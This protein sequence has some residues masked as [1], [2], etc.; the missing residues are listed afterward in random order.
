MSRLLRLVTILA[1]GGVGLAAATMVAAGA[2]SNLPAPVEIRLAEPPEPRALPERTR[3]FAADGTSIGVLFDENRRPVPLD[4]VPQVLIDAILSVE[5]RNFYDHGGIDLRAMSRAMLRNIEQGDIV[6]GGSTITQQL[7]KNIYLS[8]EQTVDRKL[9][10]A[11]IAV[12]LERQL[13]KDEILE[14]YLNTVYFGSGA[15][16]VAAAAEVFFGKDLGELELAEAALLAGVIARP[17]GFSPF[18]DP[19]LAE[20]RRAVALRRMVATGAITEGEA[21]AASRVPLPSEPVDPNGDSPRSVFLD[22][23]VRLLMRDQRLGETPE[24][25][26][27]AIFRGGLRVH[28]TLDTRMQAIAQWAIAENMPHVDPF[29]SALISIQPGDGAV[30]AMVGSPG[31]E[32]ADL[33]FNL[34]TQG[35]RQTG[36]TF[37]VVALA[38]ALEAGH[39]PHDRV[40]ATGPCT[41]EMPYGQDDWVVTNYDDA[42]AGVVDLREAMVRSYNCSWARVAFAVGPEK[43]VDMAERLGV[44]SALPAV[45]SL[46]LG[47][48]EVAPIEMANLTATLA[49]EGIRAEPYLISRVETRDGTLLWEFKPA[50]ARALDAEHARAITHVLQDVITRGTGRAADIGRPAAG[51]TGTTQS[52][53]DAWFIGYVPHLATVVWMGAPEGQI[54]MRNVEGRRVTGGSFPAATWGAYMRAVV[55]PFDVHAFTPPDFSRWPAPGSIGEVPAERGDG[56]RRGTRTGGGA[57]TSGASASGGGA[58]GG[59]GGPPDHARAR[60]RR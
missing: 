13:D 20:R 12:Q 39:H 11:M 60:G 8:G 2:M 42:R 37:K 28:T 15:Y 34:T 29:T 49:A 9:E 41:F 4:E 58:G 59:S 33:G 18:R 46:P 5:D 16:G 27:D 44:T 25:R 57:R 51:K 26:Y 31:L 45:P 30:R 32:Q 53:Y 23:V 3:V 54:P 35:R 47:T 36:S 17:Q 10:E 6:E 7:A 1:I 52:W 48:G 40:D 24:E 55:E 14:R 19:E 22:E 50:T 43:I 38:A 21:E 56:D